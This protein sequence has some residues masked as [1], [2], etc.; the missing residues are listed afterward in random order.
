MVV[1]IRFGMY[2]QNLF[3]TV[4]LIDYPLQPS[5]SNISSM[6]LHRSLPIRYN[7]SLLYKALI[8]S[9]VCEKPSKHFGGVY[10]VS[11]F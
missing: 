6:K 7:Y 8:P 10:K 3:P 1:N 4:P 5:L 9:N 2:S 11:Y